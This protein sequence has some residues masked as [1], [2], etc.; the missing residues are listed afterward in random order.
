M[1]MNCMF[2]PEDADPFL[3]GQMKGE[4]IANMIENEEDRK[5]V[6][7]LMKAHTEMMR[8]LMD[9]AKSRADCIFSEDCNRRLYEIY[10]I[11]RKNGIS[12]SVL[13]R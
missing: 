5:R 11:A 1:W 4:K 2:A 7:E 13:F 6:R 3:R 9:D 10:K 8:P 12:N